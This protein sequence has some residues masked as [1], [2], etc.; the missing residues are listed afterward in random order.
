MS[1]TDV[2]PEPGTASSAPEVACVATEPPVAEVPLP[3]PPPL[4]PQALDPKRAARRALVVGRVIVVMVTLCLLGLLGRVA[5]LQVEPDPRIA[6]LVSSQRSKAS[7]AARRGNITDRHGR[8]LAT[9]R[10]AQSLFVDPQGIED[11]GSFAEQVGYTLGYDPAWVAQ[12]IDKRENSRFVLLDRRLDDDRARKM[13]TELT[14]LPGLGTQPSLVRDYPMGVLAG[15][16]IGFVGRDGNGLEGLEMLLEP[17]LRG[18]HGELVFWRDARRRPLWVQRDGYRQP[19]N[20]HAARLTIDV[21]IQ[22]T[23]QDLLRKTCHKYDAKGGT[24]IVME[25]RTGQILAMASYPEFDPNRFSTAKPEMRK[26]RAVTEAFEPGSIFKPFVWAALSEARLARP[27][28]I[29]NTGSGFYVSPKGRKLRDVHGNGSITWDTVLVK[30]SNIGMAIVGQRMAMQD[31]HQAVR[32]FGFGAPTGSQLPGES[33]GIVNPLRQWNHY[34]HTSVPMGQEVAVT[35]LQLARALSAIA[36]GGNLVT[37]RIVMPDPGNEM[38]APIV[39]RVLSEATAAHTR[40]VMRR[41]VT[42]GTGKQA[43]SDLYTIFGK[44]GT[45]QVPDPVRGGYMEG[46][47][48]GSFI[49][50]APLN[51]PQV[52]VV[53]NIFRPNRSKGYYGGI[54]AAPLAKDVIEKTLAY[55]GVQP[56]IAPAEPATPRMARH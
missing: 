47:Y 14:K 26:N 4:S 29:I 3:K 27:N 1:E 20:G 33:P 42:D 46:Q 12:Q 37:P 31:L 6:S 19:V 49:G 17:R 18:Q 28:E 11:H 41:V 24:V 38:N 55:L 23:A 13:E 25:P 16:V 5:Q 39:E 36:N 51:N 10:V 45:A 8:I 43:K 7:L 48:I 40:E 52:V 32:R 54:V 21:T 2:Q 9:T 30:S 22:A 34:S 15:N 56:D 53:V 35:S 44:T 50:A